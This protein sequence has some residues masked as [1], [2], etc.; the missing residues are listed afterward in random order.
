M[1]YL[2]FTKQIALEAG[3]II[4]SHYRKKIGIS[5]KS[6]KSDLV[7][8]VDKQTEKFLIKI[9]KKHFPQHEILAEESAY[10]THSTKAS[11][12]ET[13]LTPTHAPFRWII[14]PLDGT[15]NY[16]HGLEYF[17]ISIGLEYKG[18]TII[19]VVYSPILNELFSAEKGKGAT[20][21]N[22]ATP[23]K[24]K[25]GP[26]ALKQ[27]INKKIAVSKISTLEES[28]LATGFH[29]KYREHNFKLFQKFTKISQGVRRCGSA[30]LDLCYTACGKLDGFWEFGLSAWDVAA[31]KLI[32][33]EAEGQVTNTDGTPFNYEKNAILA[34]N[35]K[36]HKEMIRNL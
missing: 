7:T 34:T 13:Y 21:T 3:K 33:E 11:L 18:K 23:M 30:A 1:N 9:I 31:G 36:I 2:E 28:L 29:P 22:M 27:K 16:I 20:L 12:A 15:T 25:N 24:Q 6:S 10:A 32:V 8:E 19:G 35:K 4:R 14:D 5:Q 26:T 17:A